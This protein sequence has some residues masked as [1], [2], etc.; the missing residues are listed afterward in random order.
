MK[1]LPSNACPRA[2]S[3]SPSSASAAARSRRARSPAPSAPRTPT[4]PRSTACCANSPTK[5]AS[6]AAASGCI[7]PARCRPVVLADI[8]GR[9]NDGELLG[10]ADR[11]GRTGA[12]RAAGHPH[13]HA[14]ARAARRSR[15]RRRPRAHSH[16]ADA[17]EEET[18]G[19]VIKLIDRAKHRTLG[20]F[21]SLPAAAAGW[22]RS[23]K[24]SSAAN[25]RI[26]R[27]RDGGR[28]RRRSRRGRSGAAGP[29][30]PAGRHRRRAARLDQ[31]RARRQPDRH[32]R[33][34]HSAMFFRAR[35]STK[36]K[37]ARAGDAATA[38]KIGATC[39]SSPSI[40]P[41]PRTTTTPSMRVPDPDPKQSPA[42]ISSASP[43][44]T[45]RIM[46]GPARR[47]IARR[48]SAAI[49]S[50]FPIAS[51]RCCRSAFPT[52]CARCGRMKIARRLRCAW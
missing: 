42:A 24:S 23:T 43:S 17:S 13:H 40:R 3:L 9:D 4:A 11:M 6:T 21:R 38:A 15:R 26:A 2:M 16:R 49:R 8:T 29:V 28:G 30:R 7:T 37:P 19:R 45:S 35:C 31:E 18:S 32:P 51:C 12:W 50:I 44:P 47:S 46:C 41:T 14:A 39:R 10:A 1:R 33:P 27:R 22:C 5:A 36:P 52:I 48:S 34:R 25:S 20:I